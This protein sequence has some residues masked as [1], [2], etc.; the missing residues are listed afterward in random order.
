MSDTQATTQ[1]YISGREKMHWPIRKLAEISHLKL[2]RTPTLGSSK[3]FRLNSQR[4]VSPLHLKDNRNIQ[5][6]AVL[7]SRR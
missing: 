2:S 6:T 5:M 3:V 7:R 4:I 1:L